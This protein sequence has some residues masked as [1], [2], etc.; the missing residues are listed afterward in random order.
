MDLLDECLTCLLRT[1]YKCEIILSNEGKIIYNTF[2]N[3]YPF[4]R[5]GQIDWEKVLHKELLTTLE[6]IPPC[7]AK[8]GKN[9]SQEVYIIWGDIN[10]PIVKCMLENVLQYIDEI[11][12]LGMY[13]TW[14]YCPSE[15][16]VIEFYHHGD[17]TIGFESEK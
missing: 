5:W 1:E 17:I 15:K 6:D 10:L 3:T 14:F 9:F 2:F 7:L 12:P 11:T 8:N 13:S 4:A 16:W